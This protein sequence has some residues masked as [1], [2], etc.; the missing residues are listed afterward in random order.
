MI[1]KFNNKRNNNPELIFEVTPKVLRFDRYYI[2]KVFETSF[3]VRNMSSIAH[4]F[5]AIPPK[6]QYFSLSLGITHININ[7]IHLLLF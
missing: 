2:G 7:V 3:E 6:T 4:Q 1:K 5:R